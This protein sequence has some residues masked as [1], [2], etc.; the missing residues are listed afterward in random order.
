MTIAIETVLSGFLIAMAWLYVRPCI[1]EW[2]YNRLA[3]WRA[4]CEA[5]RNETA[6][7]RAACAMVGPITW[8]MFQ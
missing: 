8:R 1:V 5:R 3:N 2:N 7:C 6:W 4:D